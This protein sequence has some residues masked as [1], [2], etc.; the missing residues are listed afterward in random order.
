VQRRHFIRTM[1]AVLAAAFVLTGIIACT[2]SADANSPHPTNLLGRWVRL[3][4]NQSWGDTMEFRPDGSMRGSAGYVI[5]PTLHW[6]I[7]RDARG[8]AQY[9]ATQADIGFC[10]N[11]RLSGDTLE[12]FGGPRG[13]TIFRRVR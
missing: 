13:N 11:Y 9:C 12:M 3:R 4:E 6:E 5:P 8:T 10:R 7:K 1:T 2:T